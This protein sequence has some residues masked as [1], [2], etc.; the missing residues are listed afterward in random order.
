MKKSLLASLGVAGMGIG[1][2]L[3]VSVVAPASATATL[4]STDHIY[5]Y[6]CSDAFT[7]YQ[8][9]ELSSDG[10]ATPIGTG[11]VSDTGA[12]VGQPAWDWVTKKAY[13]IEGGNLYSTD[14]STGVS[15]LIA[16]VT[17][18]NFS[19]P[20]NSSLAISPT[21]AAI[22]SRDC[23]QGTIDLTTAVITE[24]ASTYNCDNGNYYVLP[25]AF[26]TVNTNLYALSTDNTTDDTTVYPNQ[27]LTMSQATGDI[28]LGSGIT[29]PGY[30]NSDVLNFR[31]IAF[32][33]AGLGWMMQNDGSSGILY[34]FDIATA[35]LTSQGT[36][37]NPTDG[38]L[39]TD[40]IFIS[41]PTP[42]IPLP[43]T[44]ANSG[45]N[46]GAVGAIGTGLL[47]AGA[48]AFVIARRRTA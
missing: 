24:F 6:D 11:A 20:Q 41:S 25:L 13:F 8:L 4:P 22:V 32:D 16:A 26:E 2:L 15:T 29:I 9:L 27:L 12:C 43:D 31:A 34:S 10:T 40:S 14:V 48:V 5:A 33:S 38:D 30:Q 1:A 42:V 47:A 45:I 19:G 3:A 18:A 17:G 44:G 37:G 28:V 36:V 46:L 21:G 39:D 35:T 23:Y 7:D